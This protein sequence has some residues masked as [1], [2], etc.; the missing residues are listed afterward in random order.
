[1]ASLPG[2]ASDFNIIFIV[3]VVVVVVVVVSDKHF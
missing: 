3:V 1:M 2:R